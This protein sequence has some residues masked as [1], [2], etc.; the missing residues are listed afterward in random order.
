MSLFKRFKNVKNDE[1][2]G[3]KVVIPF[4][5][6]GDVPKEAFKSSLTSTPGL[7]SQKEEPIEYVERQI[8][9]FYT[10]PFVSCLA[11]WSESLAPQ[12][13]QPYP[14]SGSFEDYQMGF[15]DR[16]IYKGMG[17]PDWDYSYMKQAFE[18]WKSLRATWD[19][20]HKAVRLRSTACLSVESRAAPCKTTDTDS[21]D[22]LAVASYVHL[23]PDL[24]TLADKS[25]DRRR[26]FADIDKIK[27]RQQSAQKLSINLSCP[28]V[29]AVANQF[30][31]LRINDSYVLKP[32]DFAQM[33]QICKDAP[34]PDKNLTSFMSYTRRLAKF[35]NL[36]GTDWQYYLE[37]MF[38]NTAA[39]AWE[40][41][42]DM[43]GW[44]GEEKSGALGKYRW[45]ERID[46]FLDGLEAYCKK[47]FRDK[48]DFI[49]A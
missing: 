3:S 27:T 34:R 39:A 32:L 25:D 1:P 24:L 28:S 14:R 9:A 11:G 15:A 31:F 2:S 46:E 35:H 12:I 40:K 47:T 42:A 36:T 19:Q 41:D 37:N 5:D 33:N 20:G 26:S 16:M 17:D 21:D 7:P 48:I 43:A 22:M 18:G 29:E 30:P 8:G 23:Y 13:S 38:T 6:S 49:S 4:R 44:T 45:A 10:V